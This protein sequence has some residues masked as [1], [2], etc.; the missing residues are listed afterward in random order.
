MEQW[1]LSNPDTSV[2]EESVLISEV[3]LFQGLYC[4]Q[5]GCLGQSNVSCLSRVSLFQGGL[6]KGFHCTLGVAMY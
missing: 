3:S 1:N 5:T 2:T 4:T 6:N